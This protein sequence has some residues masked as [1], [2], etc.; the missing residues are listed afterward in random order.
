M[1]SCLAKTL[2]SRLD[3][4]I[5]MVSYLRRDSI[6]HIWDIKSSFVSKDWI[7]K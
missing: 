1:N 5:E 3:N 4:G 6:E 7:L 2:Y